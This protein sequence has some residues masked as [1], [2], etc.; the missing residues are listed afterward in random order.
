VDADDE[1]AEQR[2]EVAQVGDGVDPTAGL[3]DQVI[4]LGQLDADP[5]GEQV[6]DAPG[7]IPLR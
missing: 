6:T 3:V 5:A 7:V 1:L 2:P 4:D